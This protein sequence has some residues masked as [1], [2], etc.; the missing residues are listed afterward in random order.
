[1]PTTHV[2]SYGLLIDAEQLGP[3]LEAASTALAQLPELATEQ[4]WL[5]A[6]R[7]RLATA[8]AASHG[9]LLVRALRLRELESLKSERGKLLQ[10]AIGDELERLQAAITVAAGPRSPLLEMLLQNLKVPA[11]QKCN[12]AEANRFC[13]ELERR[14]AST[15]ARRV[16]GT[17]RYQAT[18]DAVAAVGTA[19]AVWRSVML[20]PP[21]EGDDAARLGNELAEAARP[22]ELAVRQ[23]KLLAQAALLPAAELLDAA[24]L[25]TPAATKRR[26]NPDSHPLLERDPPDPLAPTAEER[27]ELAAVTAAA[28]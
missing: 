27:E 24:G 2:E 3:R 6:A 22:V 18:R 28:K 19:I 17:E 16:L 9:D 20:G 1:M 11:L 26:G 7:E 4:M 25:L 23:A 8:R 10:V 21:L 14:L 5:A 15:Y 12:T 13:S